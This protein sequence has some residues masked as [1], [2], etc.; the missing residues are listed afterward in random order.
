MTS[1][2]FVEGRPLRDALARLTFTVLVVACGVVCG[3]AMGCAPTVRGASAEAASAATP[4]AAEAGLRLLEDP[5]VRA[6]LAAAL[7]TPEVQEALREVSA[8]VARGVVDG[9]SSELAVALDEGLSAERRAAAER[10]T[11]SLAAAFVRGAAE[12]VP[13]TLA[14]AMREALVTELGPALREVMTKEASP[15][16]AS[17]LAAPELR[18]ALGDV[19]HDLARSAVIGSNEAL[20]ELDERR[21]R[22]QGGMPLGAFAA[23]FEGRTWL[24]GL[25]GLVVAGLAFS[26]PFAWLLRDRRR[27]RRARE[28]AAQQRVRARERTSALLAAL[29]ATDEPHRPPRA[30]LSLL[31]EQLLLDEDAAR[32]EPSRGIE[33]R[34]RPAPRSPRVTPRHA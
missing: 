1:R 10:F 18:A 12:E 5:A 25:V 16:V 23:F 32:E 13:R 4:A 33:R 31:R 6:R 20:V 11:S 19:A 29:E 30:L 24:V 26:V 14:P 7:A 2:V 8:G 34:R 28:E 9:A 27:S 21:Q 22:G 17:M 3:L 15:A